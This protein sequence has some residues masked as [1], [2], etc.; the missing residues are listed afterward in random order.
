MK[1]RKL[2]AGLAAAATLLGG[3][4]FGGAANADDVTATPVN[5]DISGKT[6]AV[7][8][9]DAQQFYKDTAKTQ[10]R[11][12]RY[13]ELAKYVDNGAQG[14]QLEGVAIG[15]TI[16]K[17]FNDNFGYDN[18]ADKDTYGSDPW[19]WLGNQKTDGDGAVL[20]GE[21]MQKFAAALTSLATTDITPTSS[22]DNKTLTFT[23][24]EGGLYLIVDES[25][26][27][28]V[29]ENDTHKLVWNP[30]A[31]ILAG[32][33]IENATPNVANAT[34]VLTEGTIDAK[35]SKTETFKAGSVGWQKVDK[36]GTGVAGA[37][38]QVYE[39]AYDDVANADGTIKDGKTPLKFTAGSAGSWTLPADGATVPDTATATLTAD[40]QGN[41]TLTGLKLST[42]YTVIETKVPEGFADFKGKF[43]ITTG[44]QNT[45]PATFAGKD[46]WNLSKQ[47]TGAANGT[48]QVT[49]VRSIAQ[50]PLTGAAG[51][52]LFTVV[53]LLL[54]GAGVTVFAKSRSVKRALRA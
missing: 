8:A 3:I 19:M 51:I 53:A 2:F 4:A 30:T 39:G 7:T 21:K 14:V 36:A 40:G 33:K 52:G 10:L 16:T 34:G 5:A 15:D 20:T 1:M 25:G 17:A 29:E 46:A 43:T 45:D 9:T 41:Y 35:S 23:F 18:A 48:F 44:A 54:A 49:N 12:F 37:E 38:F 22:N 6:I 32:T 27:L 24:N 47:G 31:P 28:T 13:V 50:L 42:T 11:D 26:T